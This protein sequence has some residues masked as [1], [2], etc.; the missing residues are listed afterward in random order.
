MRGYWP[1]NPPAEG[2]N[3][4]LATTDDCPARHAAP[5]DGMEKEDSVTALPT[6]TRNEVCAA[7]ES[8]LVEMYPIDCT[9]TGGLDTVSPPTVT[10]TEE[11]AETEAATV[12]LTWAAPD[13]AADDAA[14]P[15]IVAEG[16]A[17]T[18]NT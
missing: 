2:M 17:E 11:L 1:Q 18:L 10:I 3:V 8:A 6:P 9:H 12:T 16:A 5:H 7:T 15:L 4:K 13:H 14:A